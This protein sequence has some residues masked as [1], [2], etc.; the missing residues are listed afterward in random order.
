M[1]VAFRN[2]AVRRTAK[3]LS[4]AFLGVF[5]IFGSGCH[6]PKT[7]A[8]SADNMNPTPAMYIT[9]GDVLDITFPG[10]SNLSGQHKVGPDG[11]ITMPIVGQVVANGKTPNQ[12]REE[13]LKLYDKE[14]QDKE[15]LVSIGSSANIIYVI[16]AVLRP[17]RVP[18]DRPLTAL[19]AIMEAGGYMTQAANLKKITVIRYEGN[20]N[21]IYQLNLEPILTGGPVPPFFLKPKDIV[22]VPVKVEWF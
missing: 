2:G 10:A 5:L 19:E 14:L 22:N 20:Q 11:T 3:L 7:T 4:W 9:Q 18:L 1:M 8:L 17:G 21:H 16:G 13:L 6:T 15:I 12:L